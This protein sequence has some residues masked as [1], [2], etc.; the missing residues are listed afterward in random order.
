MISADIRVLQID[1]DALLKAVRPYL[2]ETLEKYSD[3]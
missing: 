3:E 1:K 2:I